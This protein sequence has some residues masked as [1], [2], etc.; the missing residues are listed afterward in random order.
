MMQ[1]YLFIPSIFLLAN[2]VS[3]DW[4]ASAEM[5]V[6]VGET[7]LRV[8]N[9][10]MVS[11]RYART[12]DF[13]VKTIADD[14]FAVGDD[15]AWL[16]RDGYVRR[17]GEKKEQAEVYYDDVR[18]QNFGSYALIHAV[19]TIVSSDASKKHVR[20]TD[21]YVRSHSGWQLVASQET[22]LG[23]D[24]AIAINM[25]K[26]PD[27]KPSDG[28]DPQ[29][30]D[31]S[32]L[33]LLND[34]YVDS[35]RRADVSWYAAH[36]AP[37]YVVTSGNGSF[38]DRAAALTDFGV[39]YFEKN[40]A[41]FPVDDVKIRIFG[42]LAIIHAENDYQLKDGR[43]GISRYTDIWRKVDGRWMCVSAHITVYK[44]PTL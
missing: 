5:P 14:F 22:I 43:R 9:H 31:I 13:A 20:Y 18:V 10:R 24:S 33:R 2:P 26:A 3:G 16:D 11:S 28:P 15:G 44:S 39:P 38:D 25:G 12:D 1:P 7:L 4:Q 17:L 41:S 37:S 42:E 36:L 30:D 21:A 40:I 8:I 32:V 19:A 35:F 6:H 23:P 34:R 29:G 27:I